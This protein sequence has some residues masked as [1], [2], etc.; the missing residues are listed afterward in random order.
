MRALV[1]VLVILA[2]LALGVSLLVRECASGGNMGAMDRTCRCVGIEWTVYDRRAAD[3]ARATRCLGVV[4]SRT[5]YR[6]TDGPVVACPRRPAARARGHLGDGRQSTV[7][8]R[9]SIAERLGNAERSRRVLPV[10]EECG[11]K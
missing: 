10:C 8:K 9:R 3:G 2:V 5:C 6:I 4:A 1:K 11:S 7:T